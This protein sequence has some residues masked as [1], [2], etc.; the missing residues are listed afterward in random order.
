M[1]R[2][3]FAARLNG[4]SIGNEIDPHEEAEAKANGLLVVFGASDDL[5]EFRGALYDEVG[6]WSGADIRIGGS[7]DKPELLPEIEHDERETLA[8]HGVLLA[9]AQR[10]EGALKIKAN[11]DAPDSPAWTY[12]TDAPHVTF[13][14][15]E[16][17]EVWCRGIVID[18][19][20]SL[21]SQ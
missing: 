20:D 9:A 7:S 18:L 21:P 16:D 17:G 1:T 12:E 2:E 19:K 14:I 5:C 13:D 6:A 3:R 4:R 15:L 8:K 11:W 10:R